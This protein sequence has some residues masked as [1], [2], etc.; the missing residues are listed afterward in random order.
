MSACDVRAHGQYLGLARAGQNRIRLVVRCGNFTARTSAKSCVAR[1]LRIGRSSVRRIFGRN[2]RTPRMDNPS[3]SCDHCGGTFR[4]RLIHDGFSDSAYA[5]CDHCAFT[6]LLSGWNHAAQ[7]VNLRVHQRITPDI[8]ALL[9]PCPCG[10]LFRASAGPKCPH[11]ARP[12]SAEKAATY[13]ERDAPGNA[14]GW[15]WQRSWSGIYS[16]ILNDN[17]V[18]DWWDEQIL[19]ALFPPK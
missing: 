18:D 1:R 19:D 6:A 8:E 2:P 15:R 14:K 10:A 3:G 13:I 12:L 17:F 11:C 5:Y 4:Y 16:I 9:K 7:R